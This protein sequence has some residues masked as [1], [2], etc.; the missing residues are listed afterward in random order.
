MASKMASTSSTAPPSAFASL[1]RQSKFASY[2]RGIGQVYTSPPAHRVRGNYGFKH[3]TPSTAKSRKF[4]YI[5]VTEP[6]SPYKVMFWQSAERSA[7]WM[8]TMDELGPRFNTVS[9]KM[10][11][12]S[13]W[14]TW[15]S[16][17][18]P[19]DMEVWYDAGEFSTFAPPAFAADADGA[20]EH[21]PQRYPTRNFDR[22]RQDKFWKYVERARGLRNQFKEWVESERR[23]GR[24]QHKYTMTSDTPTL[25]HYPHAAPLFL[26]FL[27][28]RRPHNWHTELIP[29]PHPSAALSY[30]LPSALQT[31]LE[32]Q[33]LT[34]HI[35]GA[36]AYN[37][38]E[39]DGDDHVDGEVGGRH[40]MREDT[41][42]VGFAGHV[43]RISRRDTKLAQSVQAMQKLR[44]DPELGK[45]RFRVWNA[46]LIVPPRVADGTRGRPFD[47]VQSARV[48]VEVREV[49]EGMPE[50]PNEARPG[51]PAY[52]TAD[53]SAYRP[54][55]DVRPRTL[56]LDITTMRTNLISS[57][58]RRT[59]L[60]TNSDIISTLD[61]LLDSQGRPQGPDG[62][63]AE[64]IEGHYEQH[65]VAYTEQDVYEPVDAAYTEETFEHGYEDE[66]DAHAR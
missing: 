32:S 23:S 43:S 3:P 33:P 27:A 64:P 11:T 26:E 55:F 19:K 1:L 39:Q 37:R 34:G 61:T 20:H 40:R 60:A 66:Y 17:T 36:D 15:L 13:T 31:F 51:S 38:D 14:G 50:M 58:G 30:H 12:R 46:Q 44:D 2:D 35:L 29:A 16:E 48:T 9:R 52:I 62:R 25:A 57:S 47:S 42:L 21:E 54:A 63:Y 10:G 59:Y 6:D 53:L 22:L 4:K 7:R 18:R 49:H 24:N 41:T 56:P 8:N 65:D 5:N 45:G 28:Q